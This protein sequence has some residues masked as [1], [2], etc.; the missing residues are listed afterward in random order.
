ML[1]SDTILWNPVLN[2]LIVV[3]PRP[4]SKDFFAYKTVATQYQKSKK[5][6]L[7]NS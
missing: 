1:I 4:E 5:T 7:F 6:N 2:K 3:L